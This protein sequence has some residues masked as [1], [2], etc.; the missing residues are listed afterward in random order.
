MVNIL[1]LTQHGVQLL[2]IGSK[3]LKV[4]S[5][6]KMRM[7]ITII[8]L[9][10]VMWQLVLFTLQQ[11]H[12]KQVLIETGTSIVRENFTTHF[13]EQDTTYKVMEVMLFFLTMTDQLS[14][15]NVSLPVQATHHR[16]TL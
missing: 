9:G 12:I 13:I 5:T 7:D 3:I 10:V 16:P 2:L 6:L 1:Q 11:Q 15:E 8:L 4:M 14:T